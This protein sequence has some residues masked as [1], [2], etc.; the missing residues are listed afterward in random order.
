MLP[1]NDKGTMSLVYKESCGV[2]LGIAP[3]NAPIILG[4]RAFITP[5]ICGNICILK[6]SEL[7]ADTQYLIVDCFRQAGLSAGVLNFIYCPRERAGLVTET[8]VAHHAIARVNFTG[9]TAVGRKIGQICA[10]Y[11]KPVVLELGGKALIIILEDANLEEAVKAAV[12]GAMQHQG[13]V[14]ISTE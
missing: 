4:I 11:L 7:S 14:C 12:F 9:S 5:L 10:M 8:I 6:A 2:V 13:Q 1:S 3:W